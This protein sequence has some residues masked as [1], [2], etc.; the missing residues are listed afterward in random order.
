MDGNDENAFSMSFR[1]LSI[2]LSMSVHVEVQEGVIEEVFFFGDD[3][4]MT[5][6]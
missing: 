1:R 6:N 3:L 5:Q 4:A 2:D